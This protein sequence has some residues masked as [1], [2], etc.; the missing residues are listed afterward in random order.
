MIKRRLEFVWK[1]ERERDTVDG[2]VKSYTSPVIH[3][4]KWEEIWFSGRKESITARSVW[5]NETQWRGGEE[6]QEIHDEWISFTRGHNLFLLFYFVSESIDYSLSSS[7]ASNKRNKV[8]IIARS[9]NYFTLDSISFY[10][11]FPLVLSVSSI[12]PHPILTPIFLFFSLPE[13]RS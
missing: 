7:S 9:P 2:P 5:R 11:S 4:L 13:S 10:L 3:E 1:K 6:L 8:V 12:S